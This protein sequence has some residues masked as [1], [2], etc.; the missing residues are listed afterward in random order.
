MIGLQQTETKVDYQG[1]N[2]AGAQYI[3]KGKVNNASMQQGVAGDPLRGDWMGDIRKGEGREQ[4]SIKLE[5][6]GLT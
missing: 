6:L 1:L 5:G 4:G 2:V 3:T